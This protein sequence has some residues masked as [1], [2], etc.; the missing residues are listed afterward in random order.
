M[1]ELGGSSCKESG[2]LRDLR[3][4]LKKLTSGGIERCGRNWPD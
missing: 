4:E 2:E 3:P 1:K